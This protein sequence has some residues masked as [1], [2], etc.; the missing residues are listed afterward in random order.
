MNN[1][2]YSKDER[3]DSVVIHEKYD[4]KGST[5]NRSSAPPVEGQVCTC[6]N[7]EQKFV[8]TRSR[9]LRR[10]VNGLLMSSTNMSG[11]SANAANPTTF[12]RAHSSASHISASFRQLPLQEDYLNQY[13][14]VGLCCRPVFN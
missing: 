8:Y 6:K 3:D 9:S 2:F 13:S 12:S 11:D 1:I 7:C 4:I 10:F 5:V 14:L